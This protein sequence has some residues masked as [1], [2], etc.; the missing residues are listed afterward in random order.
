MPRQFARFRPSVTPGAPDVFAVPPD[1]M[2]LSAFL[3]LTKPTDPTAVLVGKMNPDPRWLELGAMAPERVARFE[4]QWMLPSS[5]LV[6]FESPQE[7][8]R[9]LG[10][11]Q[12]GLD[13]PHLDPP[14]AFSEA[15]PRAGGGPANLHW[16]VHFVVRGTGPDRLPSHPL[17]RELAYV[18]V[19]STPRSEFARNQGD[20]LELIG[21]VPRA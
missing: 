12:L 17:W 8:A 16:D 6:V 4:H 19:P 7:A 3:V 15:Y 18:S 5:Q 9:R 13:L 11:E 14:Q 10:R 2:C 20:V 1:G 21:L